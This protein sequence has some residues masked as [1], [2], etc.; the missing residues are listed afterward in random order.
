MKN[1]VLSLLFLALVGCSSH[2]QNDTLLSAFNKKVEPVR[3]MRTGYI[4]LSLDSLANFAWDSVWVFG[5]EE[6]AKS[7][8]INTRIKWSGPGVPNLHKRLLFTREN[9]IVSYID[10]YQGS[11]E[12][13]TS[14][15]I[16]IRSCSRLRNEH[17]VLSRKEARFAIFRLCDRGFISFPMVPIKCL[18][19]DEYNNE[20]GQGCPP[21]EE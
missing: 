17:I 21:S 20:I 12:G 8:S 5:G 7:I 15:P 19:I 14:L 4:V 11:T 16:S 18:K 1:I 6:S 13:Y 10:C 9:Q 3:T 2:Q